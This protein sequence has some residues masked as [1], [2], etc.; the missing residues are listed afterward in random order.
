MKSFLK[1][2][3][4]SIFI[5]NFAYADNHPTFENFEE[6]GTEQEEIKTTIFSGA[7]SRLKIK[8]HTRNFTDK[9]KRKLYKA[10]Q[11]LDKVMSSNEL[12]SLILNYQFNGNTSFNQN[13]EMTNEEIYNHFLTGAEELKP[14]EDHTMDFDLTMYRSWNPWSDV[15][16]YTKPD[17]MRIWIHSK[18]YR[19]SSWTAVD[20]AANMAHEWVHKMGFGHPYYYNDDRPHTVPYA[21]GRLV[22]EVAKKL[23]LNN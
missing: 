21:I 6:A 11:I 8:V 9:D 14:D 20:V 19:R 13:N 18:F 12:K 17:T 23:N 4:A 2:L 7:K 15:K 1:L 22:G 16:G 10:I 5:V 3:I